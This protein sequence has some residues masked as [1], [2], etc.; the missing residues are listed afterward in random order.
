MLEYIRPESLHKVIAGLLDRLKPGGR[1]ICV[2]SGRTLLMRILVG[3]MWRC[4][5]YA[6]SELDVIFAKAGATEVRHL[7][8]PRPYHT[9]EGHMLAVEIPRP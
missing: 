5:L 7:P 3:W 8:F 6:K 1:L 4:N 2:F 9:T